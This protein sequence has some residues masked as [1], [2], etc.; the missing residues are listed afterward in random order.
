MVLYNI[1]V[2]MPIIL[3]YRYMFVDENV[4]KYIII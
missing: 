2:G 1:F 4:V 3:M